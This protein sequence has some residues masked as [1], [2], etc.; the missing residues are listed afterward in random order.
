MLV[1]L[2]ACQRS[3]RT[4]GAG[5]ARAAST[6]PSVCVATATRDFQAGMAPMEITPLGPFDTSSSKGKTFAMIQFAREGNTVSNA[7]AKVLNEALVSVG[8]KLI[9][10]DGKGKPD[11]I[12]QAFN[13]AIAQDVAGIIADGFAMDLVKTGVA[14]AAAA[15]IPVLDVGAG[16]TTPVEPPGVVAWVAVDAARVGAL[17]ASYA[18]AKTNCRLHTVTMPVSGAP[19]TLNMAAGAVST[20]KKLCPT[21]CSIQQLEVDPGTF[22]TDL[23][24]QVKTTLQRSPDLNYWITTTDFFTP[25]ILQGMRAV[26]RQLPIV[27][28][29][30]G[31][32][33]AN[34][35]QGTNGLVAATLWPPSE[36]MG[37][38]YA[39]GILRAAAGVPQ[40]QVTPV[41]LVDSSNWGTSGDVHRQFPDLDRWRAAFKAAW[42]VE[43]GGH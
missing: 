34:A 31:D 43:G 30:Q 6:A 36:I 32:G 14:A 42:G 1:L 33:L 18:L 40:N 10:F 3:E 19:I 26:D 22:I 20:I 13:S 16:T 23:S 41:R 25:F 7:T 27:G 15:K 37:Y 21:D 2:T 35:M 17:Q 29:A 39:D 4:P 11:V 9:M 8:A 38:I 28:G 5:A 24:G 12:L